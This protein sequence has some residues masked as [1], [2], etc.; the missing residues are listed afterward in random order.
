MS[1]NE[2]KTPSPDEEIE[3]LFPWYATGQISEDDRVRV[4]RYLD[5]HPE[6]R[7]Q[8]ALVREEMEA[9]DAMAEA[10]GTPRAGAL[11]RLLAEIE[12]QDGPA[13]ARAKAPSLAERLSAWLPTF[14]S[15]ALQFAAAAAAIV[16]VAQAVVIGALV[17]RGD[18][19]RYE[20]ASGPAETVARTGTRILVAFSPD[21]TAKAIT[22]LMEE[23]DATIVS[24]PKG[25]GLFEILISDNELGETEIERAIARWKARSGVVRFVARAQ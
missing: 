14:E 9:T 2:L 6:A 16:I 21:A 24:G 8:L 11:G 25:A 18:G 17:G 15:P 10:L 19:A 4:E 22:A 3:M 1:D 13:I 20:T 23:M 12:A 7:G 5:E